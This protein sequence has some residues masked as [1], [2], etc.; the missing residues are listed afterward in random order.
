ML[1]R[2]L[3]KATRKVNEMV[4]EFPPMELTRYSKIKRP[5]GLVRT[6]VIPLSGSA[7]LD[8]VVAHTCGDEAVRGAVSV[9]I[10]RVGT[11]IEQGGPMVLFMFA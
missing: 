6:D 4:R 11:L 5:N 10:D 2:G 1:S 9:F 7:N 3:T 8:A